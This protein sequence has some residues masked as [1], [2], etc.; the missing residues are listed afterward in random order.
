MLEVGEGGRDVMFVT[1][2]NVIYYSFPMM[3]SRKQC[4]RGFAR[5]CESC[6]IDLGQMQSLPACIEKFE[7]S[8]VRFRRGSQDIQTN[9]SS[10][11]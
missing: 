2:A 6:P 7:F 4:R 5:I 1:R 10:R 3:G 9:A 11:S 8:D